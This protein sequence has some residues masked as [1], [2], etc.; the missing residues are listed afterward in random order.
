MERGQTVKAKKYEINLPFDENIDFYR[1]I[2]ENSNEAFAVLKDDKFIIF[3]KAFKKLFNLD[4]GHS[5]Y[6]KSIFDLL[7]SSNQNNFNEILSSLKNN[8]ITE[9][10]NLKCKRNDGYELELK[11]NLL[12]IQIDTIKYLIIS[13]HNL[14]EKKKLLEQ[15]NK[16]SR[17]V[18]QSSSIIII[19]D[20]EGKIEYT[21][22]KFTEVTGYFFEEVHN[23]KL[24]SLI[25]GLITDEEC[26]NLWKQLLSGKD[27]RGE[28]KNRKKNGEYYW[29]S[30]TISPIKND[31]GIITHFLA[32]KEDITEKK[33]MEFELKR[34]LDSSEEANRLKSTLLSNM[35]HELRTPLTGI[36]GF[37][38][39][40]RDELTN[41][42]HIDIVD[43]IL[44]SGK[45]LL[46]TLNSILNLSEIESGTFPINITEFSIPSYTKY[47]LTNY[48]KT[49]AEKSLSFSI[50]VL[51]ED[52]CA[53]GD[54]NL[55][56]QILLHIV[57][58][59]I[60][61][62]Q[63]GSV[64]VVVTSSYDSSNQLKAIVKIID[65][66]IGIAKQDQSKI[67]R[68]FRQLSEGI[69]RNFEGSGLGLA[70][71]KKMAKLMNGDITV[72][73]ELGKGSTFSIILPGIKSTSENKN[74]KSS[75][76][77]IPTQNKTREI[78]GNNKLYV[79]SIED[80]LLNAELVSLFLKDICE[81]DS[82]F[83]Y[84]QAIEKIKNKKYEAIL[85]D[86][87]LGNGPS[88]IDFAKEIKKYNE[89]KNT[90]LIAIT[91]YA[92]LR[93]EKKLLNEGFD[94]YLAKP[95]DKEDLIDIILSII[96]K[97]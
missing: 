4:E 34:A 91:G 79:L 94:Y 25:F 18:N 43:K 61:F 70:V 47:F 32:I 15:V 40:L 90:P 22:P 9:I 80:N 56:K 58:N 87:N 26:N 44:K 59:A 81:V 67:F 85:V 74:R 28:L 23:R 89:Y 75:K 48:D 86:I 97:K 6:N 53:V 95:Y 49:A 41:I 92:L 45:R 88:G 39:L 13:F 54:E 19:T 10:N 66:G 73:S 38:S 5:F 57:D 55:Y 68:E 50:E 30:A 8:H 84:E 93:D 33:E 7:N 31:E 63:K 27:W 14:T 78:K 60:K 3:N 96:S 29:E 51:D 12:P 37:A 24:D 64:K 21:N 2:F 52:I 83:N 71:A 16:L 77:K 17:I 36:I 65:T 76:I 11:L 62:T 20:L 46:I 69:R 1:I 82:A 42:E 35:S 72:E